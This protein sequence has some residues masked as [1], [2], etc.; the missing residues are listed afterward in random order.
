M[1]RRLAI[2]F[3]A[4]LAL[5]ATAPPAQAY[6]L[7]CGTFRN[8]VLSGNDQLLGFATGH[9]IGVIDELAA[10]L[11]FVRHPQCN[12]LRGILDRD[13]AGIGRAVGNQVAACP[14]NDG[15]FGPATR[16]AQQ[17]CPL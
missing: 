14:A 11:C 15:A 17:F 12:C 2:A 13:A 4:T 1:I 5:V 10:L 6:N 7:T 3:A 16:A 8:F 9:A